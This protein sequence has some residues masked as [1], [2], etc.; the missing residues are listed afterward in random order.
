MNYISNVLMMYVSD[1]YIVWESCL[2]LRDLFAKD[3][4]VRYRFLT[5]VIVLSST[6]TMTKCHF[7]SNKKQGLHRTQK[8]QQCTN[9]KN[10]LK[11]CELAKAGSSSW[12]IQLVRQAG[13]SRWSAQLV[14][15]AGPSSWSVQ[16]MYPA[17]QSNWSVQLVHPAN[18]QFS[19]SPPLA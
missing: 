17:D 15:P 12:S 14:H 7:F 19:W 11:I 4:D 18:P 3:I 10:N 13:P 16:L 8:L 5:Q 1:N 2:G 9:R 6:E